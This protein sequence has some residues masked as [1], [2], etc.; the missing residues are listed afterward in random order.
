MM[1][2]R[3]S[4]LLC[5][6]VHPLLPSHNTPKQKPG[7]T[8][9]LDKT[10]AH[11]SLCITMDISS[12]YDEAVNRPFL[13]VKKRWSLLGARRSSIK[14]VKS[15]ATHT[16]SSS[17]SNSDV[18]LS[19]SY[20]GDYHAPQPLEEVEFEEYDEE[21]AGEREM[22]SLLYGGEMELETIDLDL[23]MMNER[24]R[25]ISE[26]NGSMKYLSEIQR[27]K[28]QSVSPLVWWVVLFCCIPADKKETHKS[29]ILLQ[30]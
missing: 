21:A 27:G 10:I 1:T 22:K 17:S 28:I 14:T 5:P 29:R 8:P 26:V 19:I 3:S 9:S 2:A 20:R 7:P 24:H 18:P 30:L 6:P 12:P 16:S 23:A 11:S 25:D 4:D 13:N 15:W